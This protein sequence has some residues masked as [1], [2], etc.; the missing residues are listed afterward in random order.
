MG[1]PRLYVALIFL[2]CLGGFVSAVSAAGSFDRSEL[3]SK[4]VTE[5]PDDFEMQKYCIDQQNAAA[6]ILV[7]KTWPFPDDAVEQPC[8][9]EWPQDPEMI[10]YCLE[11]QSRAVEALKPSHA[12]K[13]IPADI[14]EKIM[15]K[16]STDWFPDLEMVLYCRDQQAKAWAAI[17]Q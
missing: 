8:Y 5:W 2:M 14:L 7:T 9:I 6:D 17:N 4:C 11:S 10:L 16:C 13:S 12:P 1:T 15:S 3:K